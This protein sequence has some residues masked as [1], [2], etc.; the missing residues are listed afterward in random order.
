MPAH[1]ERDGPRYALDLSPAERNRYRFMAQRAVLLEGER[2]RQYG[3]VPGARVA[4]VGCGP[5]AVLVEL[6]R[7]VGDAGVV[8]GVEPGAEARAAAA[9]EIEADG[10]TNA[11]VIEGRADGTGLAPASQDVVM[12]RL[13]LFHLGAGAQGAVDH[14]ATLLRPGAHLYLVDVDSTGVRFS[15]DDPDVAEAADR[16][17]KFQRGRGCDVAIGPRLGSLVVAAGLQL[18]DRAAWFNIVPGEMLALGGVLVAAQRQMRE[19]GA[20]TDEEVLRWNAARQ[21]LAAAPHMA[22]FVPQFLAVGRRPA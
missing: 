19:A 5:G 13:V 8:V 20:A 10:L 9:E 7:L 2:W 16:Y 18:V 15:I 17:R 11:R 14:L 4:D 1:G 21:R 3:V 12:V 22:Q 6:A